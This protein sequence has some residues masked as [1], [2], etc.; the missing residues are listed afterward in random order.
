[1]TGDGAGRP[2]SRFADGVFAARRTFGKRPAP[3]ASREVGF[4]K[5]TSAVFAISSAR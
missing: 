1:V 3:D 4:N 2:F 5:G